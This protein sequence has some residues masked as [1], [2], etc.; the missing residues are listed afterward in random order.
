[1]DEK[2]ILTIIGIVASII[3]GYVGYKQGQ[4][5]QHKADEK[6]LKDQC[7]QDGHESGSLKSDMQ[8]IKRRID[9]VLLEQ[10]NINLTLISHTERIARV[11]E[12]TKS[13]HNRINTIENK[14]GGS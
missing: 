7:T 5:R 3:F 4:E 12:S 8:Y 10:R 6:E 13:A 2:I 1:M 9:D 14:K 11:E